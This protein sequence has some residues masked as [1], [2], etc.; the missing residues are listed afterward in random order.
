MC[1]RP[2]HDHP[3]FCVLCGLMWLFNNCQGIR[4]KVVCLYG[5]LHCENHE[6]KRDPE[7][8]RRAAVS[9]C[10]STIAQGSG[11]KCF[12]YMG[13]A[14][15]TPRIQTESRTKV[16]PCNVMWL[17]KNCPG[18]RY[19][20]ARLYAEGIA[21]TTMS[22]ET[23]TE[24]QGCG[25]V[26]LCKKMEKG[27][28]TKWFAHI[29]EGIAKTMNLNEIPNEGE[30]LQCHV[31]IQKLPRDQVQSGLL[32]CGRH[33]ENHEF[34]RDPERRRGAAVSCCYSKIA[35]GSGT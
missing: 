27:S 7:P 1:G 19:K 28:S 17:F 8:R 30:A 33:C 20:V 35:Q 32:I 2:T 6:L 25:V 18:I 15:R 9:Y 14:L 11:T 16:K 22:N 3:V 26:W 34:K 10:Y 12:V 21:E 5:E 13:I 4:Y 24:A 31:G 29:R 23:R